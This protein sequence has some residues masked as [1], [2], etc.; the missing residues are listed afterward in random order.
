M[1]TRFFNIGVWVA[2]FVL[3]AGYGGFA[4][5][6]SATPFQI[7]GHI[8]RFDL[9]LTIGTG[10]PAAYVGAVMTVNGIDVVIPCYTIIVMPA[11]YLTPKQL[12]DKSTLPPT[13][14]PKSGLALADKIDPADPDPSVSTKI[15]DVPPYAAF[16]ASLDGNIVG[17]RY[18]AGQVHISQQSLNMS[19]GFIRLINYTTGELCVGGLTTAVATCAAPDTRVRINDP[20]GTYG[21]ADDPPAPAPLQRKRTPDER[22][23]VDTDNPT[24]HALTGYPMCV[25]RLNPSSSTDPL[26]PIT[27]RTNAAGLTTFVMTGP[28][29]T[30]GLPPGHPPILPC[31][32]A[33][34]PNE[35]VPF[36][37]GDYINFQGTLAKDVPGSPGAN[38]TNPF[39]VSAHTVVANVAVYT[40]AGAGQ[41]V[42]VSQEKSLLGTFGA[43]SAACASAIECQARLKIEGFIT[44]P[45]R[46]ARVGVY[47]VDTDA[48]G[49]RIVRKLTIAQKAQAPFGRFRFILG[50]GTVGALLPPGK[51][52]T[53]EI[54]VRVDEPALAD[55]SPVPDKRGNPP[56]I[57]LAPTV[58]NGIV[59]GQYVAPVGEYIFPE[60]VFLGAPQPELN[61]RCLAFAAAGWGI[62]DVNGTG[63]T[64]LTGIL[65]LDPWPGSAPPPLAP[66]AGTSTIDCSNL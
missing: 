31:S 63:A 53:R 33:C 32:P 16:E 52:A 5:A 40:A 29:I 42:Y 23:S 59:A 36:V 37:V 39:Y 6:Q 19:A 51:G 45:T 60:S 14:L 34:N 64:D 10:C 12:F 13:V 25:P 65:Q 1:K 56:T 28:A 18:I 24:V 47:A 48:L 50:R 61:F 17:G 54:M 35:Q 46:A 2:G 62:R 7:L 3:L 58:A 26:C 8:Q 4:A 49:A 41:R 55:G 66:P 11:A 21:L 44:D 27:N 15:L 9:D 20:S 30:T 57:P 43:P 22:F 38:P